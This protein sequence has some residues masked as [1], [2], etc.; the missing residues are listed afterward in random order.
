M[1][2]SGRLISMIHSADITVSAARLLLGFQVPTGMIG[3][4]HRAWWNPAT[5]E[6]SQQLATHLAVLTGDPGTEASTGVSFRKH[7]AV[8]ASNP[9]ANYYS[10]I[11]R[12]TTATDGVLHWSGDDMR[13]G[14]LYE[15]P[16]GQFIDLAAGSYIAMELLEAPA[17]SFALRAGFVIELLG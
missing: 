6:D 16:P 5:S 11:A 7:S 12:G 4:I 9:I 1:Q 2:R 14:C 10:D 3:R 13:N 17:A 8:D 15:P